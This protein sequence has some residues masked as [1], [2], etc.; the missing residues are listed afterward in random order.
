MPIA[1][2]RMIAVR[3]GV[4]AMVSEKC[5]ECGGTMVQGFTFEID[6]P[7]R[8][9]STWVE[10]APESSFWQG[11]N[12]PPEKCIPVGTFRCS[13]CGFLKSYARPEFVVG[14]LS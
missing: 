10:G 9:V 5:P 12:V 14:G 11:A 2:C 4:D 7:R 6:G 13:L 3:F 8:V 1:T